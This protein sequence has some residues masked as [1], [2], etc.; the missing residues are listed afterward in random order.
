MH[1]VTAGFIRREHASTYRIWWLMADD[2]R[3]DGDTDNADD[4]LLNG[5]ISHV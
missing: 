3:L 2:K 1:E 4:W 5:K